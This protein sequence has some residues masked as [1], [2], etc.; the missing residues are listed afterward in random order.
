MIQMQLG[1]RKIRMTEATPVQVPQAVASGLTVRVINNITKKLDVKQRFLE[2]FKNDGFPTQ[3]QYKQKVGPAS[4]CC[5]QAAMPHPCAACSPQ[6]DIFWQ[7]LPTQVCRRVWTKT[8]THGRSLVTDPSEMDISAE[9]IQLLPEQ[10]APPAL[11]KCSFVRVESRLPA[12]VKL[13]ASS[14]LKRRMQVI[15]L[16]QRINGVDVV[17]YTLYMQEYGHDCPAP[18]SRWVYLSYLD[19]VKYFEPEIPSEIRPGTP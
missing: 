5:D 6:L 17:L 9:L 4:Q 2:T 18:N 8:C 7:S 15:I 11:Y 16:F 14:A 12:L 13:Q 3:F 19:S 10:Q 1:I